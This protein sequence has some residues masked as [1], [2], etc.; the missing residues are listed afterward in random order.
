MSSGYSNLWPGSDYIIICLNALLIL[1]V[2]AHWS[3]QQI[4]L[5]T[6]SESFGSSMLANRGYQFQTLPILLGTDWKPLLGLLK[7]T[8]FHKSSNQ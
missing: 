4:H 1:Y 7:V 6:S 5:D 8:W 3:G 2:T